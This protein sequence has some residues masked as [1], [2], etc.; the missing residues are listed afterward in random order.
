[1]KFNV[2]IKYMG[3]EDLVNNIEEKELKRV[4]DCASEYEVIGIIAKWILLSKI[5][6][7]KIIPVNK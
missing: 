1:M 6:E 2:S 7:I 3:L 5:L 4:F